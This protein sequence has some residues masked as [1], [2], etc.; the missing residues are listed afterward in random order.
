[1][2]IARKAFNI[3]N[4]KHNSLFVVL[5]LL[6]LAC[7]KK[8]E[9]YKENNVDLSTALKTENIKALTRIDY[10]VAFKFIN[11]YNKEFLNPHTET[12]EWLSKNKIV[13]NDFLLRYKQIKD[14]AEIVDPE[15]GLDFDPII[16]A[17]DSDDKGFEIKQIDSISGYVTVRGKSAPN[18][19][20]VLKV[21]EKNGV[22]F[23]DGSG[24]I[25]IPKSK[26]PKN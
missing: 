8:S 6:F 11:D 17:Q 12:L 22:T 13:T 21:I 3:F 1:M 7:S 26:L 23:V 5:L 16:N 25:N 10:Q 19:E 24:V 2:D 15:L 20:I 9:T 18:F 14:S 4:M